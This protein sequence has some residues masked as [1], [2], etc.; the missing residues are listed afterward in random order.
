[1]RS[2]A[3]AHFD[4]LCAI[5]QRD[6][7]IVGDHDH[8]TGRPRGILCRTCNLAVGNLRDDPALA[9]RAAEYLRQSKEA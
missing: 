3:F 1:M 2:P 8:S 7:E 4:K 5:C 9:L 6:T